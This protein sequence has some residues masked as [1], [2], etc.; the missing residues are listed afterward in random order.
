MGSGHSDCGLVMVQ[1]DDVGDLG[2]D[3]L[4]KAS[5]AHKVKEVEVVDVVKGEALGCDG[6]VNGVGEEESFDGFG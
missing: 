3:L 4:E 6:A 1:N 2:R 5:G